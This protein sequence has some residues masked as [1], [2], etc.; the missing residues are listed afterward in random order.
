MPGEQ[1]VSGQKTERQV[2]HQHKGKVSSK[3]LMMNKP[4]AWHEYQIIQTQCL[5]S[6]QRQKQLWRCCIWAPTLENKTVMCL[7]RKV[8][9]MEG[10]MCNLPIKGIII[11][12]KKIITLTPV[13]VHN[14]NHNLY[15]CFLSCFLFYFCISLSINPYQLSISS[16][17]TK[18]NGQWQSRMEKGLGVRGQKYK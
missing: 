6:R 7:R 11:P 12:I 2:N 9:K 1:L 5:L 10:C 3:N 4:H 16:A 14:H 17:T 18:Y 15:V 8:F 13:H